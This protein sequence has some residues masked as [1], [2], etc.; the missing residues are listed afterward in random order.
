MMRNVVFYSDRDLSIRD[1]LVLAK[2]VLEEF[3]ED[4]FFDINRVLELYHIKTFYKRKNTIIFWDESEDELYENKIPIIKNTI[5]NYFLKIG[6]HNIVEVYKEVNYD[7]KS[8]F[9][10]L[11][12]DF[13]FQKKISKDT[14]QK[15]LIQNKNCLRFI[16]PHKIIVRQYDKVLKNFIVNNTEF[17]ELIL[18]EH[19]VIKEDKNIKLCFPSSL[20][21][22]DIDILLSKYLDKDPNL[23]YVELILFTSELKLEPKTKLKAKK[24]YEK[25]NK[26]FFDK[27]TGVNYGVNIEFS[28]SQEKPIA[29]QNQGT[30]IYYSYSTNFLLENS[31]NTIFLF[32][33]FSFLF[34]Y[35]D[36]QNR[37]TLISK[38]NELGIFDKILGLRA[39]K[40]YLKGVNFINKEMASLGQ[41]YLYSEFLKNQI[42]TSLESIVTN[43]INEKLNKYLFESNFKFYFPTK[44][45]SYLQKIRMI[46][47]EMESLLKQFKHLVENKEIDLELLEIDS[48]PTKIIDIPSLMTKRNIYG[49][50]K[51]SLFLELT[52]Q[53]CSENSFLYFIESNK[54]KYKSFFEL[55]I[56]EDITIC[57]FKEH[58][59][60]YINKLIDNGILK[61]D[62]KNFLRFSNALEVK[63]LFDLHKD[64]YLSYWIHTQ[65]YRNIIDKMIKNDLLTYDSLLFS[66]QEQYYLNYYLNKSEFSNGLDLRNKYLHGT[67]GESEEQHKNSYYILLKL[68]IIIITKIEYDLHLNRFYNSK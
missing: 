31:K 7:Y 57:D 27:N 28:K 51:N 32:E 6:N 12:R 38:L 54:N 26:E 52:N 19:E 41:L 2:K 15:I 4:L 17:A 8:S 43:Y 66:K 30:V 60:V 11:F 46:L 29:I 5:V 40:K 1:N 68:L 62:T 59:K 37:I 33:V 50:F 64:E 3:S 39:K 44:D 34:K 63:I 23:N 25:I 21:Q 49:N 42:N 16:L 35:T 56:K 55:I 45:S 9:W 36:I 24:V 65:L 20:S 53:L 48:K 10:E 61:I 58:Q 67:N 22:N 18:T 13:N 14:F 47:P